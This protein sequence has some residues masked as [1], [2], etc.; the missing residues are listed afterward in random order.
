MSLVFVKVSPRLH[1]DR[2]AL[3]VPPPCSLLT[4]PFGNFKDVRFYPILNFG[5]FGSPSLVTL[6]TIQNVINTQTPEHL[7]GH[8][9]FS[10][11]NTD[12]F[13]CPAPSVFL[14]CFI[15]VCLGFPPCVVF[16]VFFRSLFPTIPPGSLSAPPP[17]WFLTLW[18][19]KGGKGA[20]KM[21]KIHYGV[22]TSRKEGAQKWPKIHFG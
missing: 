13:V 4:K 8:K 14:C 19:V 9:P 17:P 7:N 21:A 11:K 15:S 18:K 10:P 1:T 6:L 12:F 3:I 5:H 20:P 22:K 2:T 16:F